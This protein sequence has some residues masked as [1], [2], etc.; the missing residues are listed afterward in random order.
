MRSTATLCLAAALLASSA[1]ARA[2]TTDPNQ[3]LEDVEGKKALDWVHAQNAD[4][5]KALAQAPGFT[6]LRDNLRAILDSEDRIPG[7]N[8]VG[9][10][11][12][13]FWKDKEHP[14]G[15]W[16][17]T[18]LAEYRKPKPAWETVIDLDAINAT[19][20]ASWVWH[21]ADCL[22]P[23]YRHCLVALSRGGSDADVTREFD[24][25]SKSWVKDGF[26]RPEAKG[27]LGWRDVNSVYVATDFGPGSM[28]DS[29]YAR[30]VKLWQRGTPMSSATLVYEGKKDDLGVGAF[31]DHAT[32][33]ERDF[34]MRDIGF[35]SNELFLRGAD[36]KL[37]KVPAPD[38]AIKGVHHEFLS[39]Q[40]REPLSENGK[41]YA[42][43]S[44]LVAKFDD[45]MAG[46]RNFTV[47]FEPSATA[48]LAEPRS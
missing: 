23:E 46:K 12:Y 6:E 4:S 26:E 16:R 34:V 47:L 11:Y 31:R 15:L 1:G 40:L 42:A 5:L 2:M 32:G 27:S 43:G 41:T 44:L 7:I 48:S 36:G 10:Y 35:Y 22:R 14:A 9:E 21:G 17:R 39:L 28:T 45:F 25:A 30:Q 29:G 8:K 18:T 20:K 13:N 19:E 24:L 38:S 37:R 33:F 3:W